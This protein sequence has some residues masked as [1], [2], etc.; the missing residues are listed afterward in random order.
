MG[1]QVSSEG[2][3]TLTHPQGSSE[4]SVTGSRGSR[5]QALQSCPLKT[6]NES[7]TTHTLQHL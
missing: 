2:R 3:F 4:A 6:L 5:R 7:T 1:D